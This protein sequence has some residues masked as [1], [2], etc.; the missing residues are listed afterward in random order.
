MQCG[1]RSGLGLGLDSALPCLGLGFGLDLFST[2]R[3]FDLVSGLRH[4]GFGHDW[5]TVSELLSNSL[6]INAIHKPTTMVKINSQ[7][8]FGLDRD[9]L[10]LRSWT[11]VVFTFKPLFW[12]QYS[13]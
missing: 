12:I 9:P 8:P 4:S 13:Q 3:S 11:L 10:R 5:N 7:F 6:I 1:T 2:L